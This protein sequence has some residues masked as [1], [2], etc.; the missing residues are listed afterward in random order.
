MKPSHL[1]IIL[2]WLLSLVTTVQAET[3]P[4]PTLN[5][6]RLIAG[7]SAAQQLQLDASGTQLQ[8]NYADGRTRLIDLDSGKETIQDAVTMSAAGITASA[9]AEQITLNTA[10]FRQTAAPV[11][12]LLLNP[13]GTHLAAALTDNTFLLY[14]LQDEA[15]PVTVQ[16]DASA[17]LFNAS[18]DVLALDNPHLNQVILLETSGLSTVLPGQKPF[19]FSPDGQYLALAND[20]TTLTLRRMEDVLAREEEVIWAS[21]TGH[22]AKITDVAFAPDST[23]IATAS[24]DGT[25]S[26]WDVERRQQTRVFMGHTAGINALAFSP[27]GLWLAAGDAAGTLGLWD[28]L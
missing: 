10:D 24:S 5:P 16:A 2:V 12:E 4:M 18:G 19:A 26:L 1:F 17:M 3:S 9:Q 28:V 25:I 22:Y 14:N 21:L 13:L 15:D 11:R 6:T 8:I 20:E 23:L 7:E 27:D